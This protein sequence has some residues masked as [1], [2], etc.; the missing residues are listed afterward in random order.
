MWNKISLRARITSLTLLALVLT[1]ILQTYLFNRNVS[2]TIVSPNPFYRQDI[3][4][5]PIFDMPAEAIETTFPFFDFEVVEVFYVNPRA[6]EDFRTSSIIVAV[7]FVFIGAF[8]AYFISARSLKPIR[9][10][11]EK[12]EDIDANNLTS[13][14]EPPQSKDEIARLANSFNSMLNKLNSSF[15]K[16]RFFSKNV[17]HELKTPLTSILTNIEVL[18]MDEEPSREEY[19]Y[20]IDTVKANTEHLIKLVDGLLSIAASADAVEMQCFS[21]RDVFKKIIRELDTE[22]KKKNLTV[23]IIGDCRIKGDEVLLT[24]AYQNLVHN[25]VRYNV[26]DGIVNIDLSDKG[27]CI[28]DSGIGIPVDEMENIFEPLYCVDKSRSK[29]LG[30]YGLG[31]PIA[32]SIFDKNQT[33]IRVISEPAAG[34]KIFLTYSKI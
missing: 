28:E 34:T 12:I 10:L 14:I 33:A 20:V 5:T 21:G 2:H 15:E 23:N 16:Q 32:K 4:I 26:K 7:V 22:I 30:G 9:R 31:L 6:R 19:K 18:Q 24:R 29:N 11:A 25:A 13:L 27:I 1:I 8:V 3:E 17:A